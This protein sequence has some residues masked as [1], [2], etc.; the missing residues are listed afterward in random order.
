MKKLNELYPNAAKV[1]MTPARMQYE[2]MNDEK[3]SPR[4]MKYFDAKPLADYGRIIKETAGKYNIKVL[5]LYEKLPINPNIAADKE[6]Y[7]IDGLHFNAE[8]HK[9]IADTLID[10]IENEM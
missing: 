2:N 3:P 9:V 6:K 10:F 4:E 1:F 8:G 5:D 7:T